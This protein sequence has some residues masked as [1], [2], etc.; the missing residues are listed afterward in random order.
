M[1][2]LTLAVSMY[3]QNEQKMYVWKNDTVDIQTTSMV[4]SITFYLDNI[5]TFRSD[6]PTDVSDNGGKIKFHMDLQVNLKDG[7]VPEKVGTCYSKKN[8]NPTVNNYVTQLNNKY[9]HAYWTTTFSKLKSGTT[10][11]YRPYAILNNKYYYGDVKEF[12]T[13][14]TKPEEI[15]EYKDLGLSV[16][17]ATCNLGAEEPEENGKGYAWGETT[18]KA[19][20]SYDNYKWYAGNSEYSKYKN[21]YDQLSLDSED[22]AATVILGD[23][24]RMPTKEEL[25]E[26]I[27]K[28]SWTHT[29]QNG[30]SGYRVRGSNNISIFLPDGYYWSSLLST[31]YDSQASALYLSSPVFPML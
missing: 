4:D 17:W 28:C 3:A 27:D 11:Y 24:W 5:L 29:T 23:E 6:D 15:P 26:L 2:L 30:V 25:Q 8:R 18:S 7:Q 12:T 13:T 22:D 20:F 31:E 10:Y 16:K 21:E 14:G 19:S 1:L 9:V